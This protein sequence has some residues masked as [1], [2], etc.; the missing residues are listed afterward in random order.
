MLR[1]AETGDVAA[2]YC[3]ELG[4]WHGLCGIP[5][6]QPRSS[7]A[8]R[9]LMPNNENRNPNTSVRNPDTERQDA[10]QNQQRQAN[11]ETERKNA[12]QS[13]GNDVDNDNNRVNSRNRVSDKDADNPRTSA[14]SDRSRNT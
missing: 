6:A 4:R 11:Y 5:G 7:P 14:N 3:G 1:N 9:D 2:R 10:K 13:D 12:R 8:R